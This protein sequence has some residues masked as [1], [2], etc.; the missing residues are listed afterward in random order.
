MPAGAVPDE[1]VR[2]R[3]L[4]SPR[5]R[6]QRPGVEVAALYPVPQEGQPE[7]PPPVLPRPAAG[8]PHQIS[9]RHTESISNERQMIDERRIRALLDPVDRLPVE[10]GQLGKPLLCERLAHTFG[11]DVVPDGS[12][13]L[14]YPVGHGVGWHAY[15]LVG[16]VIDVC[17]IVGTF[18][19]AMNE[20]TQP[21]HS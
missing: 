14:Q 13:A 16:P 18:A 8:S 3:P 2:P 5:R 1:S 6:C 11:P 21:A 15:T 9:E 17:T 10:A 19:S 20:C 12:T 4:K 7:G